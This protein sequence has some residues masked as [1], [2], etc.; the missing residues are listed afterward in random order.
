MGYG[1]D[2]IPTQSGNVIPNRKCPNMGILRVWHH[3]L[4]LVPSKRRNHENMVSHS[5]SSSKFL[6]FKL[7]LS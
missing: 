7:S 3:I 4:I 2:Q 5:H 6:S 1:R